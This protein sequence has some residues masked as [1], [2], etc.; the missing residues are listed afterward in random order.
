MTKKAEEYSFNIQSELYNELDNAH[1]Q[2]L[3]KKEIEEAYNNGYKKA[4]ENCLEWLKQHMP[5][6]EVTFEERENCIRQM[7]VELN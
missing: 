3:W 7:D 4:M 1:S 6:G 2:S 5:F